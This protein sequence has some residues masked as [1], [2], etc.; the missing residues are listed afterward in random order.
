MYLGDVCEEIVVEYKLLTVV[1]AASTQGSIGTV[2][3][4][5]ARLGNDRYSRP[6]HNHDALGLT[7]GHEFQVRI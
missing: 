7:V 3:K 5:G 1:V 2:N 6:A 4:R